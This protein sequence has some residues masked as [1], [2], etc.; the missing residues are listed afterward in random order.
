MHSYAQTNLQLCNQ[1][2][3]A[4]YSECELRC[5]VKGYELAMRLFAERFRASGKTFIAHL[6]GTASILVAQNAPVNVVAAGLLHAAYTRGNFGDHQSGMTKTKRKYIARE[7]GEVVEALVA[8]YTSLIWNSETISLARHGLD[9]LSQIERDVLL[10]RLANELEEHLDLGVLYWRKD[11]YINK[12]TEG[13]MIDLAND[14][15]HPALAE[16]LAQAFR[17][18][19]MTELPP[20]LSREGKTSFDSPQALNQSPGYRSWGKRLLKRIMPAQFAARL[21]LIRATLRR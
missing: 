14:I 18:T 1:I 21:R 4:G 16:Q 5:V 3:G 8:H 20:V 2:L 6:V 10:I 9:T 19:A 15:G 17:A 7:M 11:N 12:E 13:L